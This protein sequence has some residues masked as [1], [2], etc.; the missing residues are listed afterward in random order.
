M[1]WLPS[2]IQMSRRWWVASETST[3]PEQI[4]AGADATAAHALSLWQRTFVTE[5]NSMVWGDGKAV[6]SFVFVVRQQRRRGPHDPRLR[7]RQVDLQRRLR[8]AGDERRIGN[9][10]P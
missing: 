1:K 2:G 4:L 8:C 6:R 9:G 5:K 10:G 7:H 3:A